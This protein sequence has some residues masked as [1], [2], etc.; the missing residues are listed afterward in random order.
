M[1]NIALALIEK[2][3]HLQIITETSL[4]PSC[5]SLV[6]IS[7][8]FLCILHKHVCLSVAD[9]NALQRSLFGDSGW[10]WG[11]RFC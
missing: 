1:S 8:I 11:M 3:L 6:I 4:K 9:R 5:L 2:L 10:K 7:S